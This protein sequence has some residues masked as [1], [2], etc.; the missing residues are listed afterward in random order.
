MAKQNRTIVA[1]ASRIVANV[2][3]RIAADVDMKALAE[4]CSTL[5]L[6]DRAKIDAELVNYYAVQAGVGVKERTKGDATEGRCNLVAVWAR[7][8]EKKLTEKS[9]RA[10]VALSRARA[11]LFADLF[12]AKS[13]DKTKAKK[14][15]ATKAKADT[16][17]AVFDAL[18]KLAAAALKE[19]NKAA[20][21]NLKARA[22]AIFLMLAA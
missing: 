13:T 7:D 20:I 19:G 10:S 2:N 21:K 6:A 9:N 5:A 18:E 4:E 8:E 12:P 11:I 22:Q 14:A 17:E 1:L 15:A 16:P 3:A